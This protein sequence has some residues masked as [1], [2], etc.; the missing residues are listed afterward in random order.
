MMKS[1]TLAQIST[2]S[3]G[4]FDKK[5]KKEP[6]A[7]KSQKVEKKK[8]NK[9]LAALTHNP[10]GEKERNM[11]IFNMLQ[12]KQDIAVAGPSKSIS[13]AHMDAEKIARKAKKKEDTARR[14]AQRLM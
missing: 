1:L 3:M 12:K 5:L 14:K 7:P 8:S 2:G 4:K 6:E 9:G 11:K 13:N 10:S